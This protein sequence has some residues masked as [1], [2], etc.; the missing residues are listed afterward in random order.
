MTEKKKREGLKNRDWILAKKESQV[1]LYSNLIY[2]VEAKRKRSSSRLQIYRSEK[3]WMERLDGLIQ[4][5]IQKKMLCIFIV[6]IFTNTIFQVLNFVSTEF[7]IF[8]TITGEVFME[9]GAP[10]QR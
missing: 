4:R 2:I 9:T 5:T 1:F 10:F 3:I 6:Q 7:Y 8:S